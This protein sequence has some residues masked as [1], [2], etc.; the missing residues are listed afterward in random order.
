MKS[1]DTIRL[2]TMIGWLG[3]FLAWIV[4]FLSLFY[5]FGFPPSISAT[6]YYAPCITPFMIILG[7]AGILLMCYRGYTKSDDII[8]TITGLAALSICLFPCG[9]TTLAY[10]GTFMIPVAISSLIHNISAVIFFGLLAFNSIF[11]FTKSN[12]VKMTKNKKI[13]NWI[14]R[15]CGIGMILSFLILLLPAFPC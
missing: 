7:A 3:M 13:R 12:A 8:N 4:V 1:L 6:Y 5:G 14:Y 11:L 2:R 15:I 9:A 10:V